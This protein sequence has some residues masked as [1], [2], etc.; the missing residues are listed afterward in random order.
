MVK[1][2]KQTEI[3][4]IPEDWELQKIGD[5]FAFK[6]G[7]N[8]EKQFFG[9]GFPIVNYMDVY[10]N[11]FITSQNFTGKVFV[12]TQELKSFEARKGDVL[13]TRTSET[14]EE[15]GFS[16]VVLD[17]LINTVFSGFVLRARPFNNKFNLQFC[18]YCFS[19]NQVRE[20]IISNATYTTRALTNGRVL[21]E[22]QVPLPPLPEQEAIAEAL[23][24]A[25][26]WI[27]SLEQL[28]AKKRLIKQ[29]AMQELLTHSTSSGQAK[30]G[31]EVKKLGDVGK[32]L[33]GVSYSGDTDLY[34]SETEN[35]VRLLRSNN[36]YNSK[37]VLNNIQNVDN[38]RVKGH[39]II[40]SDDILICMANGSKDLVGKAGFCNELTGAGL[41]TF[42]AFMGVFRIFG[43]YN[44]YF[45]YLNFLT[46]NYRNHIDLLLSGSSINNLKPSDI[47]SIEIFIPPLTEQTR[48][49][50]ILSEM[51]AELAA[52]E[53]QLHKAR[54][55]KQGMMQELLTGRVRLLS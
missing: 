37:V 10:R 53:Q 7:L 47:E 6:N 22:I 31:W 43:D 55:I 13:F 50:T 39:Q 49:A 32:C 30:E 48:I 8:K 4:M 26:V 1:G 19:N 23:S 52:L 28:I 25:D 12:S 24:D 17:D 11:T 33:R 3:G 2:M 54:Q 35:S 36:I 27:E 45:I 51:D 38:S 46:K 16:A 29:G 9:Y 42:G 34:E 5:S 15:I 41:Y 44:K 40:L 20:Q 14:Q 21:S 18:R